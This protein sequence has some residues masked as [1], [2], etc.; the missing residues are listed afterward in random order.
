MAVQCLASHKL[1]SFFGRARGVKARCAEATGLKPPYLIDLENGNRS[2][3]LLVALKLQSFTGGE[4]AVF[5]WLSADEMA[6]LRKVKPIN[7]V[8]S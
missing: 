8:P 6:E 1:K 7:V 5:E 3:S 2:P 4:V